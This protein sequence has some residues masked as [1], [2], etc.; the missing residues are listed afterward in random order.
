MTKLT[1]SLV[2][3][4]YSKEE[5]GRDGWL[6]CTLSVTF[7]LHVL[8]VCGFLIGM[9]RHLLKTR[10]G[11][12]ESQPLTSILSKMMEERSSALSNTSPIS[13]SHARFVT[14]VIGFH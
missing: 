14:F 3:Q 10:I 12:R 6:T 5:R 11:P 2:L 7:I 8:R 13:V 9:D 1:R 4:G